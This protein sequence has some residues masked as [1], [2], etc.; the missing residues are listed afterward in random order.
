MRPIRHKRRGTVAVL[1]AG[2]LILIMG[3]AALSLD[4]SLLMQDRR[5]AQA[6]ADSAALAGAGSLFQNWR[7]NQGAD[8]DG[9]AATEAL[10]W[11]RPRPTASPMT[12][13]PPSSP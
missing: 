7:A 6:A 11:P 1:T 3:F 12:A 5:N 9:V 13:S 2:C 10:G 8:K 4:A